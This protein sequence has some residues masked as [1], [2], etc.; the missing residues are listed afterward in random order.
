VTGL[1]R[2][3]S[4]LQVS[5]NGEHAPVV[6]GRLRESELGEGAPDMRLDRFRAEPENPADALVRA[7]L[8]NQTATGVELKSGAGNMTIA[9]AATLSGGGSTVDVQCRMGDNLTSANVN[10][11]LVKIDAL[12]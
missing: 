5:Q 12:N 8:G 3:A 7:A 6:L 10:L 1:A 9:S 2:Q 4:A 11:A